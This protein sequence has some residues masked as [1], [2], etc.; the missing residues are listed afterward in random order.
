MSLSTDNSNFNGSNF[1]IA[2]SYSPPE[3]HGVISLVVVSSISA[4]AVLGLLTI[5]ALSAF[6]TRKDQ[7]PG[8]FVRTHVVVY[9]VCLLC[10]DLLQA[11]GSLMNIAWIQNMAVEYGSLCIA[12]GVIKQVADVGIAFW[13]F[14]I[15]LHTFCV[16]FLRLPL[17]QIAMWG[18]LIGTWSSIIAVVIAGPATMDTEHRGPFYGIAGQW[19]WIA[20]EYDE[21][22]VTLDYMIMLMSS[23]FSFILYSLVFL[24]LRGNIIVYGWHLRFRWHQVDATWRGVEKEQRDSHLMVISRQ[25]L[26]YPIAYTIIILPITAAR[27]TMWFSHTDNVPFAVTIF[28]DTVYLL[29]GLTNTILFSCTRKIL[30]PRSIIPKFLISSPRPISPQT[31]I[32]LPVG[33]DPYYEG[34]AGSFMTRSSIEKGYGGGNVKDEARNAGNKAASLDMDLDTEK[35]GFDSDAEEVDVNGHMDG[36]GHIKAFEVAKAGLEHDVEDSAIPGWETDLKEV[37]SPLQRAPS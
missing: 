7:T 8:L 11:V 10:C 19:C 37:G 28:C 34:Y 13:S 33:S 16:L 31:T 25:M 35:G 6:N 23:V 3:S 4:T 24:R 15:A 12:Q 5:I 17:K 22:R 30:P 27:F 18:T 9:F 32:D 36:H 26:M 29:S 21:Q 1:L 2:V 14:I 20:Q